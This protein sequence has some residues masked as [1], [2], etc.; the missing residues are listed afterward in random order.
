MCCRTRPHTRMTS[1]ERTLHCVD[2]LIV[3]EDGDPLRH[4]DFDHDAQHA[5]DLLTSG[6]S[7]V[8]LVEASGQVAVPGYDGPFS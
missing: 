8:E 3:A 5:I 1:E 4:E 7:T 2:N 6:V